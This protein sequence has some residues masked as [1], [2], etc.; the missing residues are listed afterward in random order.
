[1]TKY[2]VIDHEMNSSRVYNNKKDV[3]IAMG[4]EPGE[5]TFIETV[6]SG[7]NVYELIEVNSKG[8]LKYLLKM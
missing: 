4:G 2:I 5:N 6:E 7:W 1:M 8:E 3:I